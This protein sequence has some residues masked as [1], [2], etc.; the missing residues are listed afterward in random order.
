VFGLFTVNVRELV[1]FSGI[2]AKPN[3]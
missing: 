3:T 2:A 1:P